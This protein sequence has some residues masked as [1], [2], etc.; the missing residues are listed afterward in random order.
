MRLSLLYT[1]ST[2]CIVISIEQKY[3]TV[4]GGD[5]DSLIISYFKFTFGFNFHI[6]WYA[7]IQYSIAQKFC[8]DLT[9]IRMSIY[10]NK[11]HTKKQPYGKMLQCISAKKCTCTVHILHCY[12]TCQGWVQALGLVLQ[13]QVL[14]K[15]LQHFL[16]LSQK[17]LLSLKSSTSKLL[18]GPQHKQIYICWKQI[19]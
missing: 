12:Y 9:F 10:E 11:S 13:A 16:N 14:S 1:S 15:V 8:L 7:C 18:Q 5:L 17:F 19:C 3:I 4:G 2:T 6:V